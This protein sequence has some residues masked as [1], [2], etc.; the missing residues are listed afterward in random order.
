MSLASAITTA[1]T[2][3]G[4][5]PQINQT[6]PLL[7]EA[8]EKL[9]TFATYLNYAKKA[10]TWGK[11]IA[12][13]ANAILTYKPTRYLIL[14]AALYTS[15]TLFKRLIWSPLI[16]LYRYLLIKRSKIQQVANLVI[17][18]KRDDFVQ[19]FL[20]SV[21]PLKNQIIHDDVLSDIE[22]SFVVIMDCVND[23]EEDIIIKNKILKSIITKAGK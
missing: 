15:Y 22:G 4:A 14:S 5:E 1:V 16:Y 20:N 13:W 11:F 23:R 18:T 9:S 6:P 21:H 10:F 8:E 7:Q 12:E 3:S 2:E 17:V 19:S